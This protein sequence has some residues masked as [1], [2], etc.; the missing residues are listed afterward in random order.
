M[1]VSFDRIPFVSTLHSPLR[2]TNMAF[3]PLS[4]ILLFIFPIVLVLSGIILLAGYWRTG[5]GE[6]RCGQ[7]GYNLVATPSEHG[8][9][10]ECGIELAESVVENPITPDLIS[11]R[12][13]LRRLGFVSLAISLGIGATGITLSA[14]RVRYTPDL[15]LI[16]V[17][18]PL[19]FSNPGNLLPQEVFKQLE[20]RY[21]MGQLDQ[22]EI[23]Q[24]AK[25]IIKEMDD[26]NHISWAGSDLL[27]KIWKDRFITNAELNDIKRIWPIPE[28]ILGDMQYPEAVDV[29]I[30]APCRIQSNL[31]A[32]DSSRLLQMEMIVKNLRLGEN[33]SQTSSG[34]RAVQWLDVPQ[35]KTF[36]SVFPPGEHQVGPT[37]FR[38][39]VIFR[40]RDMRQ[41]VKDDVE[42]APLIGEQRHEIDTVVHL[43]PP[44]PPP[45]KNSDKSACEALKAEL[46]AHSRIELGTTG[47][48]IILALAEQPI[49]RI[50]TADLA[51]PLTD[52]WATDRPS[53]IYSDGKIPEERRHWKS[54]QLPSRYQFNKQQGNPLSFQPIWM[55]NL[56]FDR[57]PP[58]IGDEI[59][60]QFDSRHFDHG[61]WLRW[62]LETSSKIDIPIPPP[63]EILDCRFELR[64]RV[65]GSAE[66]PS[67]N[68]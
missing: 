44:P 43:K 27:F 47:A 62:H 2:F 40:L 15:I 68:P 4:Q 36:K 48:K 19:A 57:T 49:S 45:L 51:G 13:L 56:G 53:M 64:L 16:H 50:G 3:T 39:E 60:L 52:S 55:H 67:T 5:A 58:E 21:D 17:D 38:C 23:S 7:C 22:S 66:K 9:C 63:E 46:E 1:P 41:W 28:I 59:V 6:R 32:Y 34:R 14:A 54:I 8:K 61:S 20:M 31:S 33:P 18:L 42:S 30:F 12:R 65:S 25:C 11:R 35:S 24:I 10:P 26:P 29:K 37:R